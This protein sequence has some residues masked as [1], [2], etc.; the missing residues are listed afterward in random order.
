MK[1]QPVTTLFLAAAIILLAAP[2]A[3]AGAFIGTLD[4]RVSDSG[5][6]TTSRC[7]LDCP[8]GA[9]DE[10]E[11]C[12]SDTNGGCTMTVP[13]FVEIACGDTV[14]GTVWR[15]GDLYDGDWYQVVLTEPSILTWTVQAEFHVMIGLLEN[16][17]PGSG[18]CA[19]VTG[20]V[21]PCHWAEPCG[22]ATV[23][24]GP[25]PAG[26][27]WLYVVSQWGMP[28]V[29][30]GQSDGYVGTLDCT[31]FVTVGAT[32]D[33]TPELVYPPDTVSI[34]AAIANLHPDHHRRAA[35]R[36]DVVLGGGIS[37]PNFRGGYT[38]LGPSEVY[39]VSWPQNFPAMGSLVGANVFTLHVEDVTPPPYN[40][41]PYPASGDTASDGCTIYAVAP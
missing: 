33:C 25:L 9:V 29:A 8:P 12:G 14:C 20:Y 36:I 16:T 6:A 39:S 23:T 2:A 26:I 7:T 32:L 37:I 13:G 3:P 19:G 15:Q 35:G 34:S 5:Q 24:T 21:I 22:T 11:N 10:S 40:Q 31:P 1:S 38:N 18:D 28:D 17:D 30:C 41:P 4:G 27:H